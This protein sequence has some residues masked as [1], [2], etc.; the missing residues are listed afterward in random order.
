MS[1]VVGHRCGLDPMLLWLWHRPVDAA[2]IQPLLWELPYACSMVT[3]EAQRE[4]SNE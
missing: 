3:T 1:C 4:L 2:P